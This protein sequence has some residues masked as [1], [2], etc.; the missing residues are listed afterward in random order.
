MSVNCYNSRFV[1]TAK[2][3][4]MNVAL[5]VVLTAN[6]LLLDF[7]VYRTVSVAC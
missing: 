1:I 6:L 5:N 7:I 3:L 4:E 2:S